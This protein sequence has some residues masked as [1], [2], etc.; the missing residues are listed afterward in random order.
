MYKIAADAIIEWA[1][2][3]SVGTTELR[4]AI[5]DVRSIHSM[6]VP[7]SRPIKAEYLMFLND[8]AKAVKNPVAFKLLLNDAD[9]AVRNPAIFEAPRDQD[10][11]I[12]NQGYAW[13]S[14][15]LGEPEMSYRVAKVVWANWLAQCNYARYQRYDLEMRGVFRVPEKWARTAGAPESHEIIKWWDRSIYGALIPNIQQLIAADMREQARRG[16]LEMALAL[17][18]YYREN[19]AYPESPESL[20]GHG[21]DEVPFDPFD[22]AYA[23]ATPMRYRREPATVDGV[24]IWSI[25]PDG[26]DNDARIDEKG[27]SDRRG[28]I[29]VRVMPPVPKKS[30]E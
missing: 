15:M 14:Y 13:L 28:D 8:V 24:T 3:P 11:T 22:A 19:G 1:A 6:T 10:T 25:G 7:P 27:A 21:L 17:H 5:D 2:L 30:N 4:C 23:K 20:V 9:E 18:L 26:Y 29:I 12:A 16:L